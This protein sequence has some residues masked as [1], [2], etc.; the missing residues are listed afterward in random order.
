MKKAINYWSFPGGMDGSKDLSEAMQEAKEAGFE[1]IELAVGDAGHLSLKTTKAQCRR[2]RRQ[3]EEADIEIAGVASGLYWS[4]NLASPAAP[5]RTRAVST[6]KK[7][8]R[9]TSWLGADA[10]LVIPAAVDVFFDPASPTVPYDVAMDRARAGLKKAL[11]TAEKEGVALA[12]ENVWNKLMYSP[13]E[14]RDFIDAFGSDCVGCYFDTGNVMAYGYPEQWIRILGRRIK[15]VHL[16]DFKRAVGTAEGFC[17]LL[18]GDVDW[19]EVMKA[20]ENVGYQSYLTAEMIPLYPHH[21]QVRIRN[22][23]NAMDAIMAR[24]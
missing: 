6:L 24:R 15:R 19:P 14:M 9:I 1:A 17:D 13:L 5:D 2:I 3:A 10:L 11:P 18:E 7:L 16:K 21:P 8:I 4:Y 22:T 12:V 23:S 20:L